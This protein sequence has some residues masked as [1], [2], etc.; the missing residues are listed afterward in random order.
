MADIVLNYRAYLPLVVEMH[1][2][3]FHLVEIKLLATLLF[4]VDKQYFIASV[5]KK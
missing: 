4:C 5:H 3:S 1:R 2:N